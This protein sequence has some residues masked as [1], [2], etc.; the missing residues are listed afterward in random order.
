MGHLH[1]LLLLHLFLYK[2]ML[3]PKVILQHKFHLNLQLSFLACSASTGRDCG[4]VLMP[5][6]FLF[7]GSYTSQFVETIKVYIGYVDY[8]FKFLRCSEFC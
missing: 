6:I 2:E 5:H 7:L 1:S 4:T 8:I 3:F